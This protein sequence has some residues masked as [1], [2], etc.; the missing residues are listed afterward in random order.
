M[1]RQRVNLDGRFVVVGYDGAFHT[2]YASLYDDAEDTNLPPVKAV[3]YHPVERLASERTEHGP[4]PCGFAEL[5]QALCDW[6]LSG[7]ERE[8][9]GAAIAQDPDMPTP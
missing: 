4:Y 3:G 9:V 8:R 7:A 6:G 2:L 1:S 5:E